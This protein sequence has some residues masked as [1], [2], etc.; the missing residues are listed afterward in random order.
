MHVPMR[1][2]TT[3]GMSSRALT[4]AMLA[5]G[6]TGAVAIAA[7]VERSAA[8]EATL[9]TQDARIAAGETLVVRGHGFPRDAHIVLRAGRDGR[10]TERIGDAET[11]RRGSFVAKIHIE[12]DAVRGAYVA[13]ACHDRCRIKATLLFHVGRR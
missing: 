4:G 9:S 2:T 1:H 7:P 5:V 10:K 13:M 3:M 12:A 8:G 6:L 11:G